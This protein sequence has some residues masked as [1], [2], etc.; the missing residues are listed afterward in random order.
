MKRVNA[1]VGV[2]A[3]LVGLA[4]FSAQANAAGFAYFEQSAAASGRASAVIASPVDGSTGFFNAAGIADLSGLTITLGGT[5]TVPFGSYESS[6]GTFDRVLRPTFPPY[7]HLYYSKQ[8]SYGFGLSFYNA[9]GNGMDWPKNFPGTYLID[10]IDLRTPTLSLGGAFRPNPM[11]SIGASVNI[12]SASA[13]LIRAVPIAPFAP[14]QVFL[15]ADKAY[16][17]GVSA[18]LLINPR[19]DFRIGFSYRSLMNLAFTG[20]A[21]FEFSSSVP[22]AIRA[23]LPSDQTG[24]LDL[25]LPHIIG[26]GIAWD[27]NQDLTIEF[28]FYQYFW[29]AFEELRLKFGPP[30]GGG[31]P[32]PGNC[33]PA[34]AAAGVSHVCSPRNWQDSPQFRLGVDW[35]ATP[36]LNLRAGFIFDPAPVPSASVDPILPDAHRYDVAFGIGY[37]FAKWFRLDFSYLLVYFAERKAPALL[38]PTETAVGTYNTTAHLFGL[39][40]GLNF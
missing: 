14:G 24:S 36:K 11:I 6:A 23:G 32:V 2:L 16:G 8:G 28:D 27:I 35:R 30:T 3:G 31:N 5:Y 10:R 4:G 39:T 1:L 21:D 22:A 34:G 12:T 9:F 38:V 40:I 25:K 29:S 17:F 37:Q 20:K 15:G 18:G 7:I 33:T 19:K 13:E 26:A